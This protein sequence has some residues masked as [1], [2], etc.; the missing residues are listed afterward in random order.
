MDSGQLADV[1]PRPR[2]AEATKQEKVEHAQNF[3]GN[4]V[5]LSEFICFSQILL[6]LDCLKCWKIGHFK[7]L[8]LVFFVDAFL[9]R[10]KG[11]TTL[12]LRF[13]LE[14]KS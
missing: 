8:N 10:E 9:S 13:A 4:S 2:L 14:R 6:N 11:G 5:F 3:C 7:T 1:V 12:T